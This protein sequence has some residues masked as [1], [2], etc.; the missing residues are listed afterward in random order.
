[1]KFGWRVLVFCLSLGFLIQC[2]PSNGEKEREDLLLLRFLSLNSTDGYVRSQDG[3]LLYYRTLGSGEPVLILHGGPGLDHTYLI[4]PLRKTIGSGKKLVFFDQ[5]GTGFSEGSL[6][7][8]RPGFLTE[9]KLLQD[10]EA[11][12]IQLNLG[13]KIQILGHSWGGLYAMLYASHPDYADTVSKLALVGSSGAD[14]AYYNAFITNLLGIVADPTP[15]LALG[16]PLNPNSPQYLPTRTQLQNYYESLFALYFANYS[17]TDDSINRRNTEALNLRLARER[18]IRYGVLVS[19][20][21]FGNLGF[22]FND[23]GLTT[24][25]PDFST[26]IEGIQA[27]VLII[28][29]QDDPV[30]IGFTIGAAPSVQASLT[31]GGNPPTTRTI[32]DC[33]HFPFLEKPSQ[34]ASAIEDFFL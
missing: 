5:R 6:D 8:L 32:S 22:A 7:Q 2:N 33:G 20:L 11:L 3:T 24:S 19:N 29:G 12:R 17:G 28:H 14:R 16:V 25:A 21:I 30:P 10:I 23:F 27:S 9:A 34:F 15:I 4:E 18:T 13:E 26:R 31:A 1:M